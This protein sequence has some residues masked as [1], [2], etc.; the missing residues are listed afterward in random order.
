MLEIKNVLKHVGVVS[1]FMRE[2][3]LRFFSSIAVAMKIAGVL[4]LLAFILVSV[5]ACGDIPFPLEYS[6]LNTPCAC[7]GVSGIHKKINDC[8]K[9]EGQEHVVTGYIKSVSIVVCCPEPSKVPFQQAN[10]YSNVG[11][12][13]K[14]KADEYCDKNGV[15]KPIS[16]TFHIIG[17]EKSEVGEFPHMVAIGLMNNLGETNYE[18]G[19][20]LVSEKFVLT[21]AHCVVDL[22]RRPKTVRVGRVSHLVKL[23][24]L[25]FYLSSHRLL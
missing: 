19:G 22:R 6:V 11:Q 7:D 24:E 9:V 1:D 20:S 21:A 25:N 4:I 16:T 14:E 3:K 8:A 17:G 10:V 2:K 13:V 18:C 23:D 12:S 15:E 5:D